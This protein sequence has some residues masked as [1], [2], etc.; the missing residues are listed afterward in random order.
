MKVFLLASLPESLRNFRGDLIEEFQRRGHDVYVGSPEISGDVDTREWLEQRGI[1]WHDVPMERTGINPLKDLQT[2]IC[3]LRVF[4]KVRPDLF[5][6]YTIKPVIWGLL[7]AS[8]TRVQS[9]AVII[10]G[11]GYAFIEGGNRKRFL[12]R[13]C[14]IGLYKLALRKSTVIFFQN[15]DDQLDLKKLGLLPIHAK[16][17]V[18]N[19]SGVDLAHFHPRPLPTSNMRFLLVARLLGDKGIREY[20]AAAETLSKAWPKAE[21]HLVGG[22]D[23]SPNGIPEKELRRWVEAGHIKWHGPMKDVRQSL[24][25]CSVYVLP[26][27]R[28]GTPRS[29]LEALA[30]GRPIITTDAPG[31]RETV[32][33]GV[34][35]FLVPVRDP[36]ALA[37]AMKRFLTNP[38]LL[39]PMAEAS[40][41]IAREKY[42]VRKVNESILQQI[43]V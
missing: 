17:A 42:D 5:L 15:P 43:G 41:T 18:V 10:T 7:S 19:G 8:L 14:A 6:G 20:A 16:T 11:L 34:N 23:S 25:D 13:R 33:D 37:D 12:I 22:F 38:R 4:G 31:C 30:V 24:E 26:S 35:G 27:Y 29:V 32:R 21:F 40:L 39:H 36:I 3:L 28:E 1:N 9:R 2:F